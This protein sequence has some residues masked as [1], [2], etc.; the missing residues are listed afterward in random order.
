MEF[1]LLAKV[2]MIVGTIIKSGYAI[3]GGYAVKT[4]I[5][6]VTDYKKAVEKDEVK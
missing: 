5:R 6:Y 2:S 4:A 3:A 1:L